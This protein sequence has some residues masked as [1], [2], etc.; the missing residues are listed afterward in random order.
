MNYSFLACLLSFLIL[1]ISALNGAE[2]LSLFPSELLC[3]EIKLGLNYSDVQAQALRDQLLNDAQPSLGKARVALELL[4]EGR[5]TN[6][7]DVQKALEDAQ[8]ICAKAL[9]YNLDPVRFNKVWRHLEKTNRNQSEVSG[10]EMRWLADEIAP[11]THL[12]ENSADISTA[13]SSASSSASGLVPT[14][15]V[16][17]IMQKLQC[18]QG[19]AENIKHV[20]L[21]KYS[22]T[23]RQAEF[24]IFHLMSIG[25]ELTVEVVNDAAVNTFVVF[26]QATRRGMHAERYYGIKM[27]AASSHPSVNLI[28]LSD[29]EFNALAD[30]IA[31]LPK[32][33]VVPPVTQNQ[34]PTTSDQEILNP[35]PIGFKERFLRYGLLCLGG[36]VVVGAIAGALIYYY[37]VHKKPSDKPA[38]HL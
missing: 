8:K 13:A 38:P 20:L 3:G 19:A 12:S 22:F 10:F 26:D 35:K 1:N 9:K 29:E 16:A 18:G 27:A 32:Q 23:Q 14:P 36:A 37:K 24:T 15:F 5:N 11:L 7:V 28:T 34:P 25:K 21:V 31:P 2:L 17:D 30:Q 6:A 4:I 33:E